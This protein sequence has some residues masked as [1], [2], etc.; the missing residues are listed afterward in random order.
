MGEKIKCVVWDLD[1]TIWEGVLSEDINIVLNQKAYETILE[2]DKRG[3]LQSIA[4]KNEAEPALLK[5]KEFGLIEYFLYPQINWGSKAESIDRIQKALNFGIDTFAF[6]D[7]QQFER[8][9]VNFT[10]PE[11]R[12]IDAIDIPSILDMDDM[13]PKFITVD[14]KIRRQLYMADMERNKEEDIFEGP[15]ED[16][17]STLN[18]KF[19][20]EK[21]KEED[22]QRIEELT[23]RTHQLN[24]TG[25]IYSYNELAELIHDDR[26]GVYIAQLDDRYGTYGKIG[27]AVVE[28]GIGWEI[29]L[30]LMSCRV[31]S[32]GVG[33]VLLNFLLQQAIKNDKELY[34]DFV[35]T[36]KNRIM[37]VT[38]KF[39]GFEEESKTDNFIKLKAS[40]NVNLQYPN[41]VEVIEKI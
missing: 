2:L 19:T 11:V 38:Y 34:A 8:D 16:F 25:T 27:I 24:S 5:L 33:S 1:N 35:P 40:K 32:K 21:A 9:E 28:K 23:V 10:H 37:Y 22:L 41:Y 18:F 30:I 39:S 29:K 3:I 14:S 26:Y 4:S 15:K 13:H 12:C 6:V 17:L 7:D 31:M 36:D 20:I